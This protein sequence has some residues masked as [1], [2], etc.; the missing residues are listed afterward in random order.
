MSKLGIISVILNIVAIAA[1]VT[2]IILFS[3][4][5]EAAVGTVFL[6]LGS[7]FMGVGIYLSRKTRTDGNE[8]K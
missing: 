7:A 3:G 1:Y 4:G 6:C 5:G 2:A 8:K